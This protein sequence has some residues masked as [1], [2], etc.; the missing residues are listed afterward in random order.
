[1]KLEEIKNCDIDKAY[2]LHQ[3][4]QKD[5]NGFTNDAFNLTKEEF[6]QFI[7]MCYHHSLGKNL[8]E[9]FVPCTYYILLNDENEYVGIFKLRHKLNKVLENGA[10]HI[11]YGIASPYRGH[12]YAT[13]GLKL[14]IEKAREK[15]IK[16]IYMSCNKNNIASLKVQKNNGAYIHHEANN[17]YLTRIK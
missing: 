13:T 5:E 9:G 2:Q 15:G 16:E 7:D 8:P 14:C 11:G 6:I 17:H 1:M 12:G 3:Y 4:F 10:G